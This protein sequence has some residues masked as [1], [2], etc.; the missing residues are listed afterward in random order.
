MKTTQIAIVIFLCFSVTMHA[1]GK[2]VKLTPDI[3]D[4][5][6]IRMVV[7]DNRN[8]QPQVA[9]KKNLISH[10]VISK[11]ATKKDIGDFINNNFKNLIGRRTI[12]DSSVK[13]QHLYQRA[14][15][16]SVLNFFYDVVLEEEYGININ[17]QF[18]DKRTQT[19]ITLLD[20]INYVLKTPHE[21]RKY[22][23]ATLNDIRDGI[24][25][26]GGK[27]TKELEGNK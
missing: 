13:E 12:V 18:F 6:C 10:K 17:N 27:T 25:E 4:S 2:L 20:H 23:E 7:L 14:F 5:I 16:G 26:M 24:I 8:I 19:N 3:A 11:N 1:Q 22:D 9:I 21:L 15:D